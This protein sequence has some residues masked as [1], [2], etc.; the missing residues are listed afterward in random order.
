MFNFIEKKRLKFCIDTCHIFSAGYNIGNE[1]YIDNFSELIKKNLKWKN[2]V[3]VH[4]ND[5]KRQLN[6]HKDIYNKFI[7]NSLYSFM[8]NMC[9]L[10]LLI[11]LLHIKASSASADRRN[12]VPAGLT[13]RLRLL[14]LLGNVNITLIE[15]MFTLS[16]VVRCAHR[17]IRFNLRKL[18]LLLLFFSI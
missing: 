14:A 18:R 10:C 11:V 5:R 8:L 4:L 1:D 16:N 13:E 12:F 15:T 2:V 3:C 7:Q 17:H 6:S 9:K